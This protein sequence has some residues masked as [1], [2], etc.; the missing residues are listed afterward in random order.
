MEKEKRTRHVCGDDKA[1]GV[2]CHLHP[3]LELH[4]A[5]LLA[6][7]IWFEFFLSRATA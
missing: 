1:V 2:F 5:P 4:G 6:K 7:R 3:G